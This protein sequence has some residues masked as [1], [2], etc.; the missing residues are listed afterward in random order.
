MSMSNATNCTALF[1]I[2]K[3]TVES[4]EV[5][6]AVGTPGVVEK[7]VNHTFLSRYVIQP[8]NAT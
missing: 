4:K 7:K 8:R 3:T 2:S 5:K 6:D 1:P